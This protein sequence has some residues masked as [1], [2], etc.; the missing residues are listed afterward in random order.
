M[1][2]ANWVV[3]DS[4]IRAN[5][6]GRNLIRES[7]LKIHGP[8]GRGG[9]EEKVGWRKMAIKWLCLCSSKWGQSS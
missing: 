3:L 7:I 2:W 5:S 6:V 8:V 4:E 1:Y 9:A